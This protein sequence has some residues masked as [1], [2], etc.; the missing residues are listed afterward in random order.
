MEDVMPAYQMLAQEMTRL[1]E[2]AGRGTAAK[3]PEK[4]AEKQ[5][6]YTLLV[7]EV[8][9]S[10]HSI[11]ELQ[12]MLYMQFDTLR[13]Q[14][15]KLKKKEAAAQNEQKHTHPLSIEDILAFLQE[16]MKKD[17]PPLL[18]GTVM[19][20]AGVLQKK[21]PPISCNIKYI[22]ENLSATSAPAF[23]LTPQMDAFHNNVIYINPA[24]SLTGSSLFTT[25]AHEGFPGHLY[26][27]VYARE[28][29]LADRKNPLRG[30][31]DYP[32]YAEGW[33]FYVELLAYD[34]AKDYYAADTELLKTARSL[35]LCLSALLDL[36]IHYYGLTVSQAQTLLAQFGI[37]AEAANNI[38]HYI[39]QEPAN[40]L[41][42]YVSYLEIL[43]LREEA[44]ELWQEEYSDYRF[45]KFYLDAGPSDFR[46]LKERLRG[47]PTAQ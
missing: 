9:G 36:H 16:D 4:I 7:Q 6:Y 43:S 38:Y 25:L 32:G 42:Y 22:S 15:L 44:M 30:I 45:H 17:F 26:Q 47:Q 12:E 13:L 20:G 31:L 2:S 46:S 35:E 1:S 21:L 27:T 11:T 41:K 34:Y 29:G 5:R 8:T 40:Y 19:G 14:L 3:M 33:A 18:S 24:S 23:Y 28:N 10:D 37:P 39:A